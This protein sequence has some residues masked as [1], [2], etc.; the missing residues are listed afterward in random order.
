MQAL[1]GELA[2]TIEEMPEVEKARVHI[3]LSEDSLYKKN[4]KPATASIMLKL[5]SSSQLSR[6]QIKG[7]V[8]LV[9]HSIQGLKPENVTVIDQMAHVLNDQN[10]ATGLAGSAT[11]TQIEMTKKYKMIC[12]RV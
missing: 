12:R 7:V 1:Q 8:N 6:E 4:E 2:R 10:D 3:V 9:A 11:L 5:R